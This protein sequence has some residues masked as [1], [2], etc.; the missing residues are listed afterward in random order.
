[1]QIFK[2]S[3][4]RSPHRLT[5]GLTSIIAL[6]GACVFVATSAFAEDADNY[7]RPGPY[8]GATVLGGS[9][10]Q[11]SDDLADDVTAAIPD[12]LSR[13]IEA[14]PALGFDIYAGYRINRYVAVEA[15]FEMLP[16]NDFDYDVDTEA[17]PP[18]PGPPPVPEI[19]ATSGTVA[20]VES[21]SATVNAKFF[22]PLGRLQP[23]VLAGVGVVDVDQKDVTGRNLSESGTEVAG[24]FGGGA[25]IYLT[26]HV[27][28]H[29]SLEYVLPGSS[30]S[31]FDFIS[32]GAGLQFR[33]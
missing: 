21:L 18:D 28:F 5:R 12:P 10:Q 30:L 1:M 31:Q 2:R 15:E 19:F 23:F 27:V 24:R 29:L 20:E 11:V 32:Y 13:N 26:D 14:D 25:D 4:H 22:L 16:S 7:S 33:F 17:R 9:Y 8:F 3:P 6:I